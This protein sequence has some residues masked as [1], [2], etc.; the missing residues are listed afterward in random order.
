MIGERI[1]Q[2]RRAKQYTQDQL[3]SLLGVT[4][5]QVYRWEVGE[6]EP[7]GDAIIRLAQELDVTTDYLLGATEEYRSR[8]SE[9]DLTPMERTLINQLRM[10][11][12]VE[13]M[14]TVTGF[15]E[16]NH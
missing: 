9:G 11:Q 15:A 3:A 4:K 14:K 7:S 6:N 16:N 12:I 10:G 5:Q 1:K 13:A 8:I 2:L